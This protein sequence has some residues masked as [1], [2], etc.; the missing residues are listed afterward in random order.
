MTEIILKY[1]NTYLQNTGQKPRSIDPELEKQWAASIIEFYESKK[2]TSAP[3]EVN[4][5]IPP[6][7]W[8]L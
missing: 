6:S 7:I 5:G 8:T 1:W 4:Q 3:E 2:V